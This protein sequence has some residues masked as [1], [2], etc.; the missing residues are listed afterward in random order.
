VSK[1]SPHFSS[2]E[3]E[4]RGKDGCKS[5]YPPAKTL[6]ALEKL[7]SICGNRPLRIV[8]GYRCST[9][10][11]H[12]GGAPRSRHLMGDAADIPE[13]YATI[14]QAVEAGFTGIGSK[15]QWAIHVDTRPGTARWTY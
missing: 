13:G 14:A 4:C 12:V 15:G 11:G 9:R 3:F 5:I 2:A 7:R 10:N 8:S 6:A 1:L